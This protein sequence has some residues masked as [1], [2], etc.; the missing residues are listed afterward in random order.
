MVQNYMKLTKVFN[1]TCFLNISVPGANPEVFPYGFE[2]SEKVD[3]KK[4]RKVKLHWNVRSIYQ[5]KL[6]N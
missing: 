4:K 6:N 1:K 5:S 3:E 2:I